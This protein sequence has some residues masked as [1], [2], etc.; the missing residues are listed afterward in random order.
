[1][2]RPLLT[3]FRL[4]A[5]MFLEFFVWGAWIVP[6]SGYMNGVLGF[7]GTQI[8]WICGASALGAMVSP[9]FVGYVADRFFAT[10]RVLAVLHVAGAACLV[11][12]AGQTSFA[13]LMAA[14]MANALC[15]MPTLALVNN[16]VF[17]NIDNADRFARIAVGSNVGW[18]IAGLSVGFI[19]GEGDGN[20]FYL[21]AGAQVILALYCLTLPHTPP[22][23]VGAGKTDVFGLTAISLLK[24][25]AFL[26]FAV[27]IPLVTISKTFYTTWTNAF[28]SEIALP[29]PTAVMTLSQASEIATMI[30]LPWIIARIGLK[31]VIVVGMAFWAIRFFAFATMSVP[32]VLA[33]LLMHGFSYGFVVAGASI[34]AARVAPPGMTARAQSLIAL[35][36]FGI[37]M[38]FGAQLAGFTG[39][40]Y[41]PRNIAAVRQTAG[42]AEQR[43]QVPLPGWSDVG[44]DDLPGLLGASED[45]VNIALLEHLPEAGIA[46]QRDE[47]LRIAKRDLISAFKAADRDGNGI[48]AGADWQRL[49]LHGWPKIWSWGAGLAI[50][51]CLL[52][53]IGG[54][55]P[56]P[57]GERNL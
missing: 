37:G 43:V 2:S 39:H 10:E 47:D 42:G 34:Y 31:R 46:I 41:S 30:V 14:L 24:D 20:F 5:L 21:A 8:G 38:F 51:A 28:L 19:L 25:P 54:R 3:R 52:F 15:F 33:G 53:W 27:A 9:L 26:A 55:E 56:Q 50:I 22:K 35:L 48:V 13:G 32:A 11:W 16:L 49:R 17:R 57:I 1:M 6:I 29:R 44:K 12:A 36:I 40:A 4:A 23:G 7:S 18:I 45:R